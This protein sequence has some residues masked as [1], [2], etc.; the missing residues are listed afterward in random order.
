MADPDDEDLAEL[1]DELSDV[2]RELRD[3]LRH[4]RR[5][6]DGQSGGLGIDLP[7][8]PSPGEL[9]KF[10]DERLIPAAVAVLEANIRALELLQGAIRLARPD[11]AGENAAAARAH[12]ESLSR[13]TLE[14]LDDV[15][16]DLQEAAADGTLPPN[17][18][19]RD[20]IT[21]ARRL[22]EEIDAALAPGG[23]DAAA[24]ADG[25]EDDA[26]ETPGESDDRRDRDPFGLDDPPEVDVDVEGELR[27]I[28]AELGKIEEPEEEDDESAGDDGEE[29]DAGDDEGRPD[30]GSGA[31]R[32]A[33]ESET[34]GEATGDS[35]SGDATDATGD[36]ADPSSADADGG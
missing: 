18:Q 24:D 7:S 14:R 35:T 5:Q 15:L 34:D 1:A 31:G 25:A 13:S 27:S 8:P 6:R 3:E 32:T 28:K 16:A 30:D 11:R 17:A 10:T 4:S 33:D 19:A 23:D 12:A 9:L 21:E 26:G 2:L 20:V 22:R 36:D 29:S